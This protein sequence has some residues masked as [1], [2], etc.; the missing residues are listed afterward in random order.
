MMS[1]SVELKERNILKMILIV[2]FACA[3]LDVGHP[4]SDIPNIVKPRPE[5]KFDRHGAQFSH[6]SDMKTARSSIHRLEQMLK[7]RIKRCFATHDFGSRI[8]RP[9]LVGEALP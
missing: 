2:R 1:M 7:L 3:T 8:L 4:I 5:E 6:V 9:H